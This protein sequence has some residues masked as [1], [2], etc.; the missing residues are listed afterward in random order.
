MRSLVSSAAF[1]FAAITGLV[2]ACGDMAEDGAAPGGTDGGG[3]GARADARPTPADA[4][5]PTKDAGGDVGDAGPTPAPTF[6]PPPP[7]ESTR[8][9]CVS[10]QAP[11]AGSVIHYTMDGSDPTAASPIY[12]TPIAITYNGRI[13]IRAVA[14]GPG[15]GSPPSAVSEGAYGVITPSGTRP[16][17]FDQ[18]SGAYDASVGVKLSFPS[19]GPATGI[20]YTLDGT[21]PNCTFEDA[22]PL[23]TEPP[24]TCAGDAAPPTYPDAA[25]TCTS[26]TLY[27]GGAVVLGGSAGT[28]VTVKAIGCALG[29]T[30][31]EVTSATYTF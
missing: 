6:A 27:D 29:S 18:G 7:Y 9:F 20:C 25:A 4:S 16:V 1:G 26:G 17:L 11:L 10:L 8:A 31:G 2:I 22:G 3:D 19:S 23:P 13:T 24:F 14:F 30:N 28:V 21:P 5:G 12:S 15:R